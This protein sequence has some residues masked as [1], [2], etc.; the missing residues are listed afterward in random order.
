VNILDEK[1]RELE[2]KVWALLPE[3][4]NPRLKA[5]LADLA[6]I[7]RTKELV[8][9]NGNDGGGAMS[10]LI[11]AIPLVG[12]LAS[13]TTNYS[14]TPERALRRDGMTRGDAIV[15]ILRKTS[16][17]MHAKHIVKELEAYNFKVTTHSAVG[18][19]KGDTQ[20]RFKNLGHSYYDIAD[21]VRAGNT[22]PY[23]PRPSFKRIKGL[24]MTLRNA[25]LL[26]TEGRTDSFTSPEIHKVL[27]ERYPLAA[28]HLLRDSVSVTM[29]NLAK[30]DLLKEVW[31]GRVKYPKH[32]RRAHPN[33]NNADADTGLSIM[34]ALKRSLENADHRTSAANNN[35]L[36]KAG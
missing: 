19:M 10:S 21:F 4:N 13:A 6:S 1:E 7:R 20:K 14:V 35:E 28:E 18:I 15:E 33:E 30:E 31:E 22:N 23:A 24:N 26:V 27:I 12:A 11:A 29:N 3:I 34:E 16:G 25:V 36:A 17:G 5:L 2:A 9:L 32:Y 8:G